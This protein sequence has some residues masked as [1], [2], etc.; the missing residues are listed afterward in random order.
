MN[1][2]KGRGARAAAKARRELSKAAG[3]DQPIVPLS[4]EK[5]DELK[6][7]LANTPYSPL[8][9]A[10]EQLVFAM[11]RTQ[12]KADRA[13]RKLQEALRLAEI[14]ALT[15]LPNR[16]L[17]FDRFTR[18]IA[19]AKRHHQRLA[20]LFLDLNNFK[21]INDTLGHIVGDE[22]L[23]HAANCFISSVR[24]V[25]T[26]SRLGGDEFLILL[27]EIAHPEDA[28]LIA[29]KVS[30]AL[31]SPSRI[32]EHVLRLTTSIGISIYPDDGDNPEQLV[33]RADAAMYRA[34]RQGL[35]GYVFHSDSHSEEQHDNPDEFASLKRLV[36]HYELLQSE[37]DRQNVHLQEA[38]EQ[39]I[40]AALTAQALQS[41]AEEAERQQKEALT[42]LAHELRTALS[43]IRMVAELL[44]RPRQ[45][46]P[47]RLQKIFERQV[48][49]LARVLDD[50]LHISRVGVAKL[51]LERKP[52]VLGDIV[53][54]VVQTWRPELES[55][56]QRFELRMS[57]LAL[58]LDGDPM[59]I[60]QILENLLS[61]A[62]Q[63]T[64]VGGRIELS[65]ESEGGLIVITLTDNGIGIGADL[66]PN[67]F[68]PF[69]QNTDVVDLDSPGL[70]IG[71]TV[72]RE[73]VQAHG[74][75]V[76]AS[77]AGPGT[78]SQFVVKLP[79]AHAP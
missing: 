41:A 44:R 68:E 79:L 12:V 26:V 1:K 31:G 47:E 18:A 64:P 6:K 7:R 77:S 74:G 60:E 53:T 76:F 22:V 61:N 37:H 28:A 23:K 56:A 40:F 73:L 59:R 24:E 3:R 72:V 54:G 21:Q 33:E 63:F 39:L 17:F 8:V 66:L 46:V 35:G 57:Q 49:H 48:A 42:L 71:L 34:K 11:L 15:A 10:N 55:R 62:C 20:L 16:V 9:E 32:G 58:L 36:S 45:Q 43:P 51:K 29:R 19:N 30:T 52:L 4:P 14:D 2:H 78:G 38:N 65:V 67:I 70:G 50:L 5:L 13:E 69:V 75:E 27:T 25:D